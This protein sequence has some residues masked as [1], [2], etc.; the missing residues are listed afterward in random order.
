MPEMTTKQRFLAALERRKPDRL[1]VTTHHVMPSYLSRFLPGMDNDRFF[2]RFGLDPIHWISPTR[3]DESRGEYYDPGH[4]PGYLESPR[5]VSDRWRI[6]EEKIPDPVYA[7]TRYRFITPKKTLT[8]VLQ[9]NE[10]TSWVSERLLKEKS[11]IDIIA[12]NAPQ[13]LCDVDAVNR[14]ADRYGE[15]AMIRGVMNCFEVYGQP[16]CWQDASVLYGIE[17]L[18]ME[19]FEDPGWVHSV[20]GFLSERKKRY[21]A[22][23]AGARYDLLEHGGGDA[24]STVI[25][26]KIFDHFVAPYDTP[27]IDEAHR[28]GQRVVY[29]TCGG[30]MPILEHV[31]SMNPDAMETFTP[32]NMGGDTILK[33]AKRRVG[34][35]VCMIGGFDQFHYFKG[36]TPE[37]TRSEVR[38]CFAEAGEGGGYI[39]SPSDHF[40]E[41]DAEL[42]EAFADEARKCL[43]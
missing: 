36:C 5:I 43:Y 39:L 10:H 28:A 19:T 13:P 34:D 35:R 18:I 17:D 30:M 3:P 7:T 27:V 15:E 41:A 29:H 24:S 37:E 6:I 33:E 11:D 16:G 32:K 40:F 21:A 4:T 31:S 22:S 1:P 8:M 38:R 23:T 2:A 9:G 14:A 20:L 42:M 26:P 12:A 25:S